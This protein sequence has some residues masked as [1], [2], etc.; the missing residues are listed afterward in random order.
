MR[1]YTFLNTY[2]MSDLLESEACLFLEE[3]G[4]KTT[5]FGRVSTRDVT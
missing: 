5:L 1:L 4:L 2:I 3:V